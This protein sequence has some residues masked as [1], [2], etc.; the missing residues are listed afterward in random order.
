MGVCVGVGNTCHL[1]IRLVNI[2]ILTEFRKRDLHFNTTA[3]QSDTPAALT[4]QGCLPCKLPLANPL[5][6]AQK[7]A[8][9]NYFTDFSNHN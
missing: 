7:L 9:S 5:D 2:S 4:T 6:Q 8:E 1:H 3:P